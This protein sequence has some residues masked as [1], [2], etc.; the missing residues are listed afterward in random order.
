MRSLISKNE[1]SHNSCLTTTNFCLFFTNTLRLLLGREIIRFSPFV[2]CHPWLIPAFHASNEGHLRKNKQTKPKLQRLAQIPEY[3]FEQSKVKKKKTPNNCKGSNI[4]QNTFWKP[5][6][7]KSRQKTCNMTFIHHKSLLTG[8]FYLKHLTYLFSF[9]VNRQNCGR[10]QQTDSIISSSLQKTKT[11]YPP[12]NCHSPSLLQSHA[13]RTKFLIPS[14]EQK[15]FVIL[16]P[17][18]R[19]E[20]VACNVP[21]CSSLSCKPRLCERHDLMIW[22]HLRSLHTATRVNS[23]GAVPSLFHM[24]RGNAISVSGHNCQYGLYLCDI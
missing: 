6:I 3:I 17:C 24:N 10:F 2:P 23:M 12:D 21:E 9:A 8:S 5:S 18:A 1:E 22:R 16:F 20:I 13:R 11:I 19:V 7:I 14:T 4:F 15:T